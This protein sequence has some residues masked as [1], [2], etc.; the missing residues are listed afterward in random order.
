MFPDQK[1][2]PISI[3]YVN[4]IIPQLISLFLKE[5]ITDDYIYVQTDIGNV[6]KTRK[7]R[8]KK[9]SL[10]RSRTGQ[11]PIRHRVPKHPI[12]NTHSPANDITDQR[13][14]SSSSFEY[15]EIVSD[16]DESKEY[17]R[18]KV[19]E[20]DSNSSNY[21]TNE[22]EAATDN[23]KREQ[24]TD[25]CKSY[26]TSEDLWGELIPKMYESNTLK[27]F[28]LLI[29][30]LRNGSIPMDNIVFL[31]ML[32][33]A[34][35][36]SLQNTCSMRYRDV[37]KL[38][39]LV[40][41]RLCKSTGL[42]F[43]SG[44]KNWGQVVSKESEKSFYKGSKAK[45]NF[46]VP[47]EKM[48]RDLKSELPKVIP[49]GIIN[50][51]IGLLRN[52]R[53]I[54]LMADG[55]L[56]SRGLGDNF[57]GDVNLFGHESNPNIAELQMDLMNHLNFITNSLDVNDSVSSNERYSNICEFISALTKL[58]QRIRNYMN[59][60][61]DKLKSCDESSNVYS[62]YIS[63]LK[64]EIFTA[65]LWIKKSIKCNAQMLHILSCINTNNNLFQLD[66]PI[67]LQQYSNIR[68]LHNSHYISEHINVVDHP[69]V[70]KLGSDISY[71]I[72]QQS[73]IPAHDAYKLM[74][75]DSVKALRRAFKTHITQE[76]PYPQEQ[77]TDLST[78]D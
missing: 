75:L 28:I 71:D 4:I 29:E 67:L 13:N 40:V 77:I 21:D 46:A 9:L 22:Y 7:G 34:K 62:K 45:I 14:T 18:A 47:D 19:S 30:G 23:Q 25:V 17:K 53:D 55:K 35:F 16:S 57:R 33:R 31:L 20:N 32:E 59:Q 63:K 69:H 44:A 51:S 76:I 60:K 15:V 54:I 10:Y 68:M 70:F 72:E 66:S 50:K 38:F 48:L 43:F 3:T 36:G 73:L 42:K 5:Q 26:L 6:R 64:T 2:V 58:I 41:Y 78:T 12:D 52:Q 8:K 65:S 74:G 24:Y 37:T 39:W 49:P 61:M 11:R 27:D 56:L 1:F